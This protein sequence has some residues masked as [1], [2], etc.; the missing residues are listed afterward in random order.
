[1]NATG[2]IW[3]KGILQETCIYLHIFTYVYVV[4]KISL[5]DITATSFNPFGAPLLW[6]VDRPFAI[7]KRCGCFLLCFLNERYQCASL[8][9]ICK[10]SGVFTG[11]EYGRRA[12]WVGASG[13]ETFLKI[14]ELLISA[15]SLQQSIIF[16]NK[17]FIGIFLYFVFPLS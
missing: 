14:D 16:A 8:S 4:Q 13:D 5:E 6:I 15:Q 17:S 11:P 7:L 2:E 12:T 1:M 9:F 10:I 3:S